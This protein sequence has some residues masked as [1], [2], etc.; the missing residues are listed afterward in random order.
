M[1][2]HKLVSKIKILLCIFLLFVGGK[3][4]GQCQITNTSISP[5][6]SGESTGQITASV[7]NQ[8]GCPYS[9]SGIYWR[10]IHPTLGVLETSLLVYTN[11]YQFNNLPGLTGNQVYTIQI[12]VNANVWTTGAG[13]TICSQGAIGLPDYPLIVAASSNVT[14]ILCNGDATG[15]ITI[16]ANGGYYGGFGELCQGYNVTWSGPTSPPNGVNLN[17]PPEIVSSN[18]Q[19]NNLLAG[20]YIIIVDD[21]N[22]CDDTILVTITQP[23]PII[24]V[25]TTTNATCATG[26]GSIV[27]GG[28]NA[29]DGTPSNVGFNISWQ[30]TGA[31]INNPAGIEIQSPGFLNY[32]IPQTAP[33][34]P[35]TPGTYAIIIT[36]NN[37]C[38]NSSQHT[39]NFTNPSP[40]V[41]GNQLMCV[42]T[43]QQLSISNNQA[44]V[45]GNAWTSN[46]TNV[47]VNASTGVVT[48]VSPGQAI[49]TYTSS[50][51]CAGTFTITVNATPTFSLSNPPTLCAGQSAS[52]TATSTPNNYNYVWNTSPVT[53]QNAVPSSSVT[54]SPGSTTIYTVTATNATTG[55][56][57]SQNTTVTVNPLPVISGGTFICVN[58][59][60]QL[61]GTATA[62]N[63]NAWVSNN[64]GVATISASGLV[65]ALSI[66]TAQITYTNSLGCSNS[67]TVNVVAFPVITGPSAVCLGS[68][69]QL[70][71]TGTAASWASSNQSV[72]TVNS[73]G[74]VSGISVGNTTITYIT[75]TGCQNT[76]PISVNPVPTI[77]GLNSVCVNNTI[78]LTGSG[79]AAAWSTSNSSIAT[80]SSIGVVTGVSA[81][82]V[83]VIYTNNFGCNASTTVTVNANPIITGSNALCL[84]GTLQLNGNGTAA[85]NNP[86]VSSITG[87][88]SISSSGLITGLSVGTSNITYTNLAGCS[89]SLTITVNANPTISG[90]IP[91]CV[92]QTNNLIGSGTPNTSTPW[93]SS[94]PLIASVSNLGV[95]TALAPG[96]TTITYTSD[97]GCIKTVLVQVNANPSI[98]GNLSLCV[99]ATSQ[100]TGSA[101]AATNTPWISSNTGVA[102]I[103]AS[104]LVTAVTAGNTT[105]TYTNSNGCQVNATVAVNANPTITGNTSLCVGSTLTLTGNGTAAA[106]NAWISSAPSVATVSNL[107]VVTGISAGITTITYTNNNSCT[108]TLQVTVNALPTVTGNTSLCIGTTSQLTGSPTASNWASNAVG[109]AT[110]S[111]TGL[112]NAVSA[113]SATITYTNTTGCTVVVPVTVFANPTIS[114]VAALCVSSTLQLTGSGTAAAANAWASSNIAVATISNSGLVTAVSAGTTIITYINNNNCSVTST[115]TVNALPVVTGNI[116][117]CAG[118]STQLTGTPTPAITT[119]WS[120]S[121]SA[122]ATITNTGLVNGITAGNVVITYTNNVG[123]VT[124]FNLTV[125]PNPS[126]SGNTVLCVNTS[127]QLTGSGIPATANPWTSSNTGVATISNTGLVNAVSL[128]ITTITYVNSG[129]CSV[130]TSVNVTNPV[131]PNFN[132]I[133]SI[134]TGGTFQLP[135]NSINSIQGAWSPALNNNQTTIYTFT[136]NNGQCAS[137]ATMTVTVNSLPTIAGNNPIC[138]DGSLPLTGTGTPNN[139]NPW[140]SG[141]PSIATVSSNGAVIGVSAGT[142]NITYT[143]NIGCTATV[144]VTVNG[145]PTISGNLSLCANGTSQLNGSPTPANATP[146]TSG[147]TAVATINGTGL[148]TAVSNGTSL[149]T[150]TNSQGCL[151][152]ATITVNANPTITG[153]TSLCAGS[154]LNLTG[155]GTAAVSNAW[156]SSAPS[157]ATVSNLGVVTGVTPGPTTITYT[158]SNSCTAT[159]QVTVNA[160]PTVTGNSS[161]CIGATSQLS[162]SATASTWTSNPVGVATVSNA[163]LVVAISAGSATITYTNTNGCA[164]VV[165]VTV[166]ANP[167]ISGGA[168]L[169]V[170]STL[171]LTG[172][173]TAASLNAWASSNTAVATISNTGQITGLT[174]GTTNIT[175]TNNNNCSLTSTITVNALPVVTGNNALCAGSSTQLTGTP[176]P[177]TTTPWSSSNAA[178]ATITNTGLVNG[179]TAG[180]VVITYTNN[181][182]CVANFN[183]TVNPTTIPVFS[184]LGP[185]CVNGIPGTLPLT[186][187]NGSIAGSWSPAIIA[188]AAVGNTTYNF[189]PTSVA[190]PTC[191]TGATMTISIAP[192]PS[193]TISGTTTVCQSAAQPNITFTGSGSTPP[194]TF[195]YTINDGTNNTPNTVTTTGAASSI[196]VP[197]STGTAGIFTYTLT[198]VAVGSCSNNVNGQSAIVTVNANVLPTFT[199]VPDY[200]NGASIPVLPTTSNNNGGGIAGTWSPTINNVAVGAAAVQTSYTFTPT[201]GAGICATQTTLSITVH[202]NTTPTFTQLGPYC[203]N[204]TPASLPATSNNGSIAGSWSPAIIAT[205][206][207]GNTTYNFTPTSVATPTC[208]TGAT[209]TIS[210][211]PLPSATIS[212]TTTVCQSAAQPNIT[213]TGSGSTP[214]YTFNYTINDGTNNTPNTVTTTGAA[215]SITVPASTGTAGIF[216]YTLTSV[217][218]GSCSNNVNGQ[219]AIVTVNAIP[220]LDIQDQSICGGSLTTIIGNATPTGGVYTWSGGVIPPNYQNN[221]IT[222]SPTTT[223]TYQ[224]SYSLNNCFSNDNFTVTVIQNPTASV[225]NDTICLGQS[226]T[227]LA[228]PNGASYNW[229]GSN[230]T[231]P[232]TLQQITVNPTSTTTYTVVTQIGSC[233]TSTATA[234]VVVNPIPTVQAAP[235]QTI[236]NGQ[237]V[238]IGTNT[239]GPNGTYAWNPS[240]T[241]ASLTV[242]P[243]LANPTLQQTF[244]YSVV[245]TLNG[246]PSAPSSATVTVNPK[247]TISVNS[248]N[249]CS[250]ASDTIEAN[251]NLPGGTYYWST[252]ITG[253]LDSS[254]IVSQITNPSNQI[255]TFNYSA[256][257]V[258]NGCSSDTIPSVVTVSPIPVLTTAN[259]LPI[260]S[261]NAVNGQP[262]N[263]LL[264]SNTAGST[265]SWSA[266]ANP[267]VTGESTTAQATNTIND[268][269]IITPTPGIETVDYNVINSFNGCSNTFQLSVVVNPAPFINTINDII[270]SGGSFDT[271]P[272]PIASGNF[273]PSGTTYS[274]SVAANNS[275]LNETGSVNQNPNI[276][277]SGPLTSSSIT[278]TTLAYSVIPTSGNCIGSTFN[279]NITVTPTPSISN[280][281]GSI[282][283]GNF[284]TITALP[285]DVIPPTTLYTWSIVAD[286]PNINGQSNQGVGVSDLSNQVLVNQTNIPQSLIYSITPS[287]GPCPG[288]P[289]TLTVTVNPGPS[290]DTAYYSICSGSSLTVTLGQPNDIVPPGTTFTWNVLA[291]PNILGE[292]SNSNPSPSFNTGVLQN[293]L[294]VNDTVEYTITPNGAPGIP[295]CNGAPFPVFVIVMP[296]PALPSIQLSDICSGTPF[297][298][299]PVQN[300]SPSSVYNVNTILTWTVTPPPLNTIS[301]WSNSSGSLNSIISQTLTNLTNT[302]QTVIYNVLAIDTVSN[303][304]SAPFTVTITIQ[305]T[306]LIQ[307]Q[308]A[309]VCSGNAFII[310]PA[311]SNNQPSQ[312]VPNGT[313]YSWGNPI[314]NPIGLVTGGSA[315]SNVNGI[316]QVLTIQPPVPPQFGTLTYSITPSY[317]VSSSLTCPGNPFTVTVNVSPIPIVTAFAQFDTICFG[318]TTT[319][320]ANGLPTLSPPTGAYNWTPIAQISGSAI[321]QIITAAPSATTTYIVTYSLP[322]NLGGCQSQA[323]PVTVTVQAP[324]NIS[325]ITAVENTICEGGCTNITAN[326][327]GA[328]AVDSVQWSTG[329]VTY[330]FPHSIQVCPNDT[331]NYTATAFLGGCNGSIANITINVNPDPVISLQPYTDT[332]ICVGGTLPLTV[333]V[334]NGAGNPTYQWYQNQ[335][336][337]NIGGTLLPS[338]PPFGPSYQPQPFNTTGY[339]YYY[340]I[341]SYA[342]NGCGFLASLPSEIRVVSD[343]VVQIIG[344]DET[345]CIGGTPQCINAVITGGVGSSTL[346]WNQG[347]SNPTF[348]PPNIPIG[349]EDYTVSVL[350]TGVGCS[351]NSLDTITVSILP[352]PIVSI[353]GIDEVCVG[354][355]VLLTGTI[356]GGFGNVS[357]YQWAESDPAGAPFV[358]IPNSNNYSY[359]TPPLTNNIIYQ[360]SIIQDIEGCDGGTTLPISVYPDPIVSLQTDPYSC[361]GSIHDVEAIVTGGT[362]SSTNQF[363]WYLYTVSFSDSVKEQGPNLS[364]SMSYLSTGDT[365]VVV[366][367]NN[368]G[369]G[370]DLAIDTTII[371]AIEPAIAS[372]DVTPNVQSFFNPTFDFINTSIN[373]TNYSWNL[374]ECNPTLDY[375]E[376]FTT[377]T[378]YYD[379]NSFNIVNYTYGCPPGIYEIQLI[380]TN[381]GY[382]PDTLIQSIKIEPDALLYVPN[383]FTPDGKLSNNYFYPVF[384]HAIDPNDYVF[385]IYNRWGEIIFETNELPEIPT[386]TQNTKGAWNGERPR[387]LGGN[388]EVEKVQDQVYIWE[389]YYRLPNTDNPVRI[390]GH[391]TVLR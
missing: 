341:I 82:T 22:N 45:A 170:S 53:T 49:I 125:N 110:V 37:G 112:I 132:P 138:V 221:Q 189:T 335:I 50:T 279:L 276:F 234:T 64:T 298:Y 158:N 26:A 268:L 356:T 56:S 266:S 220:V 90:N 369:F 269:L 344:Q 199:A 153:N 307:P 44:P 364:S 215:S 257:Y 42:G 143:N 111:N 118:S 126:I 77:T 337:S 271:I 236:C 286:N 216:T 54:V 260:C 284:P 357:N 159:L 89:S 78:T 281:L 128:G 265:F 331:T 249:I 104:G 163:G 177:A 251:P 80:V 302:V 41:S 9:S 355:E 290:L 198:S 115:I 246:C 70:S 383:A 144:T 152:T 263:I 212:G 32:T 60:S 295:Q 97:L 219:S 362:P 258:L 373:A 102:T 256:W 24:P 134:C 316:S 332:T 33:Y 352:D 86:W 365:N 196:T 229:S 282:C 322:L 23:P 48:A 58:A 171:Q 141:S 39:I 28:L 368:S 264:T 51:G 334:L 124:T 76:T 2:L 367:L 174:A 217:A 107:G 214:P 156:I 345:I 272:N 218:V 166:F 339:F 280:Q 40:I 222:L 108:A 330:F 67:V 247:P 230:I 8:C 46:N 235:P 131:V 297:T 192:L 148:V 1:V 306:P 376:L 224:V 250:G 285:G 11:N 366:Y 312:I 304:Q 191:A 346:T 136:P 47:S 176:T 160:L 43:T 283:S 13:G 135:N 372:F 274:W 186:S 16:S 129:G 116:V 329:Q 19:M 237:T 243:T 91:L 99:N 100:L 172:S 379:P 63:N 273:I 139:T 65:S 168:A 29:Q 287:S 209:M 238:T 73:T 69:I 314:S 347:G 96:Q 122:I 61:T 154:T 5:L 207:V 130:I 74:L 240:G 30:L 142:A 338:P 161:L 391:V 72:A 318:S 117:L 388:Q 4:L 95:I 311:I 293:I 155:N 83:S 121:N 262:L 328:V 187:N 197:A 21:F 7:S 84:N 300:L 370:C 57:A 232:T 10:I 145:N 205:A 20:N 169:C 227:L 202:P 173:G 194:Y 289:F 204:G 146:W 336:N 231:T 94:A 315:Q 319:L 34:P 389:V 350:Q 114:G 377:P 248:L 270:C 140:V 182:G 343:P 184:Q 105:I 147:T 206:A 255:T 310:T 103:S 93:I 175:Y 88:A 261:G 98:S 348:C 245:Y 308:T 288:N 87:V 15:S 188:T 333:Q 353:I 109:I 151:N 324:P 18:Y 254:I 150:Y 211:A 387:L 167:T 349:I 321:T 201:A 354:A 165:P 358:N 31:A 309:I 79:T 384:S 317:P 3:V 313:L 380:A 120:S 361:L 253:L 374:G 363:T 178:I 277:N 228:N 137:T 25:I 342:P 239:S 190:T 299:N 320:Q 242:S 244:T 223:T 208:A 210:I 113:G 386:T 252:G 301:G 6:C 35:L 66:G 193:A 267:N 195:N 351:S 119:P 62:A 203:Q 12:S 71:G 326:F 14:N 381:M 296:T 382:C 390:T 157:V 378:P 133:A 106:S 27:V 325:T 183:L 359:T 92:G 68:T 81:G 225:L 85:A 36:D 305:P 75:N 292:V 38:V 181:V 233:P 323:Y 278:N 101:S 275:V 127:S 180:N 17:C 303:C 259:P 360:L 164:V 59:Q 149:I 241:N 327:V 52:I 179:I 162:G 385:R 123:C 294:F 340:C 55:C 213:F 291:N 371:I 375:S 200:C 185:Y 226:T